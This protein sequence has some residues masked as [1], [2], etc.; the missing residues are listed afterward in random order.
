MREWGKERLV[1]MIRTTKT[2]ETLKLKHQPN[3]KTTNSVQNIQTLKKITGTKGY[4]S[5]DGEISQ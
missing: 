5:V 2:C 4:L 1:N 3:F